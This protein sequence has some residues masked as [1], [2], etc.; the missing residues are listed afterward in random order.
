MV[1]DVVVNP[2]FL[3]DVDIIIDIDYDRSARFI[4]RFEGLQD[5]I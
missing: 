5:L 4:I 1:V 2:E 3:V